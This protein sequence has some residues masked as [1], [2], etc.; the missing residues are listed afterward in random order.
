MVVYLRI[1]RRGIR[2]LH[3]AFSGVQ[4]VQEISL[5]EFGNSFKNIRGGGLRSAWSTFDTIKSNSFSTQTDST[6][7]FASSSTSAT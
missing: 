6:L 2:W 3:L 7:A 5:V 4:K 1:W